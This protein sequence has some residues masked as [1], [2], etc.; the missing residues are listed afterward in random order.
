MSI[1]SSKNLADPFSSSKHIF[2]I[3][4]MLSGHKKVIVL[5]PNVITFV[6][7]ICF[8]R[9]NGSAR[10][11]LDFL[12]SYLVSRTS[13]FWRLFPYWCCALLRSTRQKQ[14]SARWSLACSS[15]LTIT[16]IWIFWIANPIKITQGRWG[17][18]RLVSKA[19]S[20]SSVSDSKATLR[21]EHRVHRRI[22]FQGEFCQLS[23]TDF[24]LLSPC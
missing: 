1:K 2:W 12:Y 4:V 5:W 3:E 10:F 9:E 22:P 6:K 19:E 23:T 24:L 13:Q 7:S 15:S 18:I 14:N 17:T 20:F 8:E 21:Y 16:L 11:L